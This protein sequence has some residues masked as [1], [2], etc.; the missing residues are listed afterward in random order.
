M[1]DMKHSNRPILRSGSV[2]DWFDSL[3]ALLVDMKEID[4]GFPVGNNR[5]LP[6]GPSDEVPRTLAEV[7]L[8]HDPAIIQFYTCCNGI[9]LPGVHNG[10]FI[11]AIENL[12]SQNSNNVPRRITGFY[13]AEVVNF[14]STGGG[15]YFVIRK[16]A[17][18][19]LYLPHGFMEDGVYHGVSGRVAILANDFSGF[20]E[21]LLL[22]VQAFVRDT[23]GHKFIS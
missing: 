7:G 6:P 17:M 12:S 10:Y 9:C 20:L 15:E 19:V 16:D 5:V 23:R 13:E 22:D 8:E 21:R 11:S 3:N 4:F 2:N 18:D 14:G 1:T